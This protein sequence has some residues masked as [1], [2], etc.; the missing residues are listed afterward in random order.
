MQATL[1]FVLKP[2][3]LARPPLD[4]LNISSTSRGVRGPDRDKNLAL[5]ELGEVFDTGLPPPESSLVKQQMLSRSHREAS[6][7]LE[8]HQQL[9]ARSPSVGRTFAS[10]NP[11]Q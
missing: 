10:L 6:A 4:A 3:S 5:E 11:M 1:V 9:Q 2:E 7:E 8:V